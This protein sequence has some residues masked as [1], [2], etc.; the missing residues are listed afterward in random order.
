LAALPAS[1]LP[2][3]R[4]PGRAEADLVHARRE[5]RR[6]VPLRAGVRSVAAPAGAPTRVRDPPPPGPLG[7]PPNPNPP[8]PLEPLTDYAA[9]SADYLKHRRDPPTG[10]ARFWIPASRPTAE[11]IP[12][13]PAPVGDAFCETF[14]PPPEPLATLLLTNQVLW[15]P[16]RI[17][18]WSSSPWAS[19]PPALAPGTLSEDAGLGRDRRECRVGPDRHGRDAGL[20]LGEARLLLGHGRAAVGHVQAESSARGSKTFHWWPK[21]LNSGDLTAVPRVVVSP[22]N[23]WK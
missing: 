18:R 7:A 4:A 13:R 16:R 22:A 20:V 23:P 2:L 10:H 11:S 6:E 19:S 5:G 3:L 14:S 9:E 8:P 17:P 1:L 21:Q 12:A 15:A